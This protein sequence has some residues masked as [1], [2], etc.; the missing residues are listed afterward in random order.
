MGRHPFFLPTGW[1]PCRVDSRRASP[2][3]AA[4]ATAFPTRGKPSLS[5]WSL[6]GL[7]TAY[8]LATIYGTIS[9][10][11]RAS[12]TTGC[13]NACPPN[14]RS[15][16]PNPPPPDGRPHEPRDCQATWHRPPHG[17]PA[18][19][20]EGRE[21]KA[22]AP[23][24]DRGGRCPA[25]VPGR[26]ANR[27]RP[28]SHVWTPNVHRAA[29]QE[30]HLQL[31]P[32]HLD[33]L[34]SA[35]AERAGPRVSAVGTKPCGICIGDCGKCCCRAPSTWYAHPAPQARERLVRRLRR[36]VNKVSRGPGGGFPPTRP[37]CRW[38]KTRR[39]ARVRLSP[40]RHHAQHPASRSRTVRRPWRSPGRPR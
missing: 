25:Q 26:R 30:R 16:A 23:R 15:V 20:A 22:R 38:E 10:N 29:N 17:R 7:Y 28:V 27:R 18:R 24:P 36:D 2:R 5:L 3:L 14:P 12:R 40:S 39:R 9:T 11:R 33:D 21:R 4:A 13:R 35:N 34:T 31:V 6:Y 1:Q 32:H 37:S 8:R 19:W